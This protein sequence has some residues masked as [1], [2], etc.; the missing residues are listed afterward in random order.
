MNVAPQ[1]AEIILPRDESA[2]RAFLGTMLETADCPEWFEGGMF[3][4]EGRRLIFVTLDVLRNEGLLYKLTDPCNIPLVHRVA[5][6]NA[7]LVAHSI[8]VTDQ[9]PCVEPVRS[10]LAA[11]IAEVT[12]YWLADHYA[13]CIKDAWERRGRIQTATDMLYAAV[14]GAA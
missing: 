10:E 7:E 11:C 3:F 6:G 13:S 2:E 4:D 5:A 12:N 9:W 8:D 1:T 14:G